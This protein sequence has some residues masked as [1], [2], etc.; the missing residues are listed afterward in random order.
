M[1]GPGGEGYDGL[2]HFRVDAHGERLIVLPVT[3]RAGR[4]S[5]AAA[6]YRAVVGGG[7]IAVEC[8]ACRADGAS[9][10][11]WHLG[12]PGSVAARAEL[13]DQPYLDRR[14]GTETVPPV[15]Q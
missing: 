7:G 9:P 13:D 10:A 2:A 5:L 11:A 6:G 3:C 12:A 15:R 8:W 14:S 4:H 1:E